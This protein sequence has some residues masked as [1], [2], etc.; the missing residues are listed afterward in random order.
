[1]FVWNRV[2]V[3]EYIEEALRH[4]VIECEPDGCTVIVPELDGCVTFGATPEEAIEN[5]RDAVK[6]WVETA[7]HFGDPV[8]R[9][10]NLEL[11]H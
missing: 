10:G 9:L 2:G 7:I 4:A 3:D 5:L 8:P 1:M 6:T 11:A